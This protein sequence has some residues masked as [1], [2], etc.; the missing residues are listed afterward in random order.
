MTPAPGHFFA[1]GVWIMHEVILSVGIDIGTT[2]TQLVFSRLTIENLASSYTVPR[3]T[4]VNKEIIYESPIYFTPL[5]SPVE[6]DADAVKKIV[7]LEYAAAG[8]KPGEIHTGAVIIT[9]ETARKQNAN[10][11]LSALS[12][13]AGDFVVATAGPDLESVLSARG[14]GA[15]LLSSEHRTVVAN[16]DVG[17]G[18]TN[19]AVFERGGLRG[20]CCLD[21]GGRL[22]K[23]KD[24][25]IDYIFPGIARLAA[26]HGLEIRLGSQAD[27]HQLRQLC[28]LMADQL[29][30]ALHVLLPD[31]THPL[32]YTN[33]GHALPE[34][35][36]IQAVTYSGGVADY[37]YQQASADW[38]RYGDIGIL[39]GQAIQAQ[40]QLSRL[41]RFIPAETIRAT[42]VGAGTHTTEISGSTIA[43]VEHCLPMKNIPILKISEADETD[44]SR[45]AASIATQLPLFMPEGKPEPVAIAFTGRGRSRFSEIQSLAKAIIQGA[46]EVIEHRHPL[47]IV[48]E[49]DI[50][51][52]LGHAI[53]VL[54]GKPKDVICIDSIRTLSGDYIDIGLPI[55]D[56]RVVPVVI[57]TLIFNT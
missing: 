35:P 18:T 42:V 33:Q 11:V 28:S 51:K 15:D 46:K 24:N 34:Q 19:I 32:M 54:L 14:A 8:M 43:Y 23:V 45:L 30:M 37:V 2:T 17:G 57:K 29:A 20:T 47:I 5:T 3:I 25:R 9:G 27:L 7:E 49:N 55:A 21:I 1:K 26:R 52:A 16:L 41:K 50:G 56:G 22:V 13:M 4:I 40:S 53:R 44:L 36:V 12:K 38:F 48:V 39:L 10:L 31:E 6:I